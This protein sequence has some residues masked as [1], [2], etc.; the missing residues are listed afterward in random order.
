MKRSF[1]HRKSGLVSVPCATTGQAVTWVVLF[2]VASAPARPAERLAPAR[3]SM[4]SVL[5]CSEPD[6]DFGEVLNTQPLSHNF[7]LYNGS[8]T[9]VHIER[10]ESDCGCTATHLSGYVIA[11]GESVLLQTELLLTGQ[12]GDQC[13]TIRV[14]SDAS[15]LAL[16][17]TGRAVRPVESVPERFALGRLHSDAQVQRTALLSIR[18]IPKELAAIECS[19]PCFHVEL[20]AMGVDGE[21]RIWLATCPPL[22]R[23]ALRTRICISFADATQPDILIPITATVVDVPS[24]ATV[25]QAREPMFNRRTNS[26]GKNSLEPDTSEGGAATK[27]LTTVGMNMGMLVWSGQK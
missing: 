11:A 17:L 8:D 21:Y 15:M 7:I 25:R 9:T 4:G 1:H 18:S 13:H 10:V 20:E 16:T 19:S 22:P 2:L 23:G 6:Y 3:V 24:S 14:Y 27:A 5:L 12:S 26:S